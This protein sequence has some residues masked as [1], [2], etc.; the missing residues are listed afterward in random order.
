MGGWRAPNATVVLAELHKVARLYV[1]YFQPSFKLKSKHREGAKVIKKYHAPATPYEQLLADERV[2]SSLKEQLR[3][4]F[5]ALDPV[6]LLNQI[7]QAQRN[8]ANVEA[9]ADSEQHKEQS[10]E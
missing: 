8:I 4:Q 5:A 2:G 10:I 7:R 6:Q 3:T 1:N 9:G